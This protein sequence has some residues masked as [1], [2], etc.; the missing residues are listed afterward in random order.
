MPQYTVISSSLAPGRET[1]IRS[2]LACPSY[3]TSFH[4]H[5]ETPHRSLIA[6]NSVSCGVSWSGRATPIFLYTTKAGIPSRTPHNPGARLFRLNKSRNSERI[7]CPPFCKTAENLWSRAHRGRSGCLA[8]TIRQH[9]RTFFEVSPVPLGLS[10]T[11]LICSGH[12]R[13]CS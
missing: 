12:I 5:P 1:A 11:S 2:T 7:A 4:E 13:W 10:H 8:G 6:I 9:L 3:F